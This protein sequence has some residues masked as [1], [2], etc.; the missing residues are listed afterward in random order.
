M[1]YPQATSPRF[2]HITIKIETGNVAFD[3]APSAEVARVLRHL[4]DA[5]EQGGLPDSALEDSNGQYC[6]EI[7]IVEVARD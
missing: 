2:E 7:Q 6:G 3:A 4:A 5:F 1:S